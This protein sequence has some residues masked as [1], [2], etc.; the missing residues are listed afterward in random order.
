MKDVQNSVANRNFEIDRVGI[1]DILYPIS[2]RTKDGKVE[3]TIARAALYVH[4]PQE[5]KGTHMSRFVEI[6]NQYY[7]TIDPREIQSILS[8]MKKTLQA[9]AAYLRLHFPYFIEKQA[10]VSGEKGLLDYQCSFSGYLNEKQYELALTVG[11]PITLCCPCSKE[12]SERGAHNQR[13]LTKVTV[14]THEKMIWI[15]D[16]IKIVESSGS[17]E[18]F[19]LLKRPDEKF[20]TEKAYDNPMFVEDV[21]REVAWKLEKAKIDSYKIETTSLESIHNHAAY[22]MLEKG[23]FQ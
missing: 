17:C 6:L 19:S 4:L 18:I 15:E 23:K 21:I 12:I 8:K 3:N 22:A 5:F 20:V 9:K 7:K 13:S 1:K 14:K 16:V 10:P 2:L 11:V